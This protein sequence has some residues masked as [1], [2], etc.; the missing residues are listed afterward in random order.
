MKIHSGSQRNQPLAEINVVPFVDIVLVL[1]IVFMITAPFIQ[2]GMTVEVPRAEAPEVK[3]K[4]E[5]LVVTIDRQGKIFLGDSKQALDQ[6]ELQ[7]KLTSVYKEKEN[8]ALLVK[9]DHTL[10]YGEVIQVMATAL[11]AGVERIGMITQ[12]DGKN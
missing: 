5:D 12:P 6:Q 4:Q 3:S 11:K 9:A 10:Q 2:Q 1:L 8:K 7:V